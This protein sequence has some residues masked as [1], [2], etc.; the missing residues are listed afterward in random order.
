M[1]DAQSQIAALVKDHKVVL[2]MK[3]SRGA[4]Q[5]GFSA[6]V[7]ATL[8]EFL[9]DYKT[10]NVLADPEVRSGIKVFSSWPTIPQLYVDG[11]FVGGCDIVTDMGN[12]GELGEVLGVKRMEIPTPA[13]TF[14]EG[15]L[16]ALKEF[17]EGEGVPTVRLEITPSWQYGMDFDDAQ[18]GDVTLEGAGYVL[19]M[20]RASARKADGMTIDFL[21]N[22]SGAGFKIENPNEPPKVKLVDPAEL[23]QWIEEGKALVIYDVR[24][25]Q[26]RETASLEGTVHFDDAAR[27][28]LESAADKDGVLVFHCHHGMRS[29]RAAEHALAMGYT[30]VFNL[31]GGIDAWSQTVDPS[32][33]RY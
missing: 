16:G 8:D 9:A 20:S 32:V 10:V 27:T 28:A 22:S 19:V 29:Q 11:Q 31:A 7:V 23:K 13:V 26:E 21:K 2:F 14:T 17:H 5:C 25:E 3:G 4:P 12:N 18:P 1:T 24:T 30:K 15:A 6:R 33:P